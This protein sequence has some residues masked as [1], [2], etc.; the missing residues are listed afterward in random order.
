MSLDSNLERDP[1]FARVLLLRKIC[2][3][4]RAREE[5]LR[6]ERVMRHYFRAKVLISTG[7]VRLPGY[8]D[9]PVEY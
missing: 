6:Q 8:D 2:A 1:F 3:E 5:P 7:R 4:K 9:G